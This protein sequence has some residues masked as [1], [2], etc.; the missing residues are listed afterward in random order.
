VC[1]TGRH[2]DRLWTKRIVA[3]LLLGLDC[4]VLRIYID[5]NNAFLKNVEAQVSKSPLAGGFVVM[6][7]APLAILV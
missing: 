1:A 4:I 2:R 6:V 3:L 5:R 7:T